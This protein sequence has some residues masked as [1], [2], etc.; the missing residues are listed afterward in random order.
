MDL[1]F[2]KNALAVTVYYY[3][4]QTRLTVLWSCEE[5]AAMLI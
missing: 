1:F 5:E 2:H 3:I 4:S